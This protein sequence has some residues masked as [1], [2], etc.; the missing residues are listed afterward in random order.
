M[1]RLFEGRKSQE[2]DI[3]VMAQMRLRE[4]E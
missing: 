1:H 4:I 2:A 3:G